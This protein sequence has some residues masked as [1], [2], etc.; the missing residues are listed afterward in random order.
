MLVWAFLGVH[1]APL[2]YITGHMPAHICVAAISK[3]P[4]YFLYVLGDSI[5]KIPTKNHTRILNNFKKIGF[6][7]IT[8][9]DSNGDSVVD[10][11]SFTI[12]H[13]V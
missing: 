5:P 3:L 9:T 13:T 2:N 11:S 12:L 8:R 10:G 1:P 6:V 7:E 4:I